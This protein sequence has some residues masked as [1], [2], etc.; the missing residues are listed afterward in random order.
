M[1]AEFSRRL[2]IGWQLGSTFGWGIYGYQI[3]LHWALRTGGLPVLLM[4]P[5][6]LTPSS[7]LE[8]ALFRAIFP[9]QAAYGA[10]RKAQGS[11]RPARLPIP[12]LHAFGNDGGI[13]L[14]SDSLR[15][16]GGPNHG[17]IF[18]E[19]TRF[20]ASG[21]AALAACERVIAG[22]S[23]NHGILNALGLNNV[24]ACIQGVDPS[25]FH[26]APRLGL[27]GDRF[28][29]FSGGKLEYRK[30]Q[31]I[32]I[33]AFRAFHARH[34]DSVLLAAWHNPWPSSKGVR[35]MAW[36]PHCTPVPLADDGSLEL[37]GWLQQNG[38]D[39]RNFLGFREVAHN[40]LAPLMREADVAVFAN[41]CEGGTNLVAMECMACGVPT[42][43]S[44]NTG[45]LDIIEEGACL[46][47]RTQGAVRPRDPT[48]GTEGWGESSVE[49]I[50][51]AL[52]T[53][54]QD[55]AR[56]R[57]IARSGAEWMA[58]HDWATQTAR[59]FA[60]LGLAERAGAQTAAVPWAA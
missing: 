52:E 24:E 32:V 23:W 44:A 47:L 10:W 13:V 5:A 8:T 22:S 18:F 28:V 7:P 38:L 34:P 4:P 41:R 16:L 53:V 25:L 12:V 59:L 2:G 58:G 37:G 33:A 30:G 19:D 35:Q 27:L 39:D 50:V 21:K 48:L 56:A 11:E 31:D 20:S 60:A 51:A 49:E 55:R 57:R 6:P 29:V 1:A 15:A 42:I 14:S 54:Y 43:L 3:A 36:S 9:E 26:P 45:H 17:L 46:P 40:Q